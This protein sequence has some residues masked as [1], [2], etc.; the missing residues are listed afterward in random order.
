MRAQRDTLGCLEPWGGQALEALTAS[1]DL[2]A[3]RVLLVF[4]A[5][6]DTTDRLV[7][8]VRRALPALWE[9]REFRAI[10]VWLVCME[11][12][13]PLVQLQSMALLAYLALLALSGNAYIKIFRT[14]GCI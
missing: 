3:T 8:L 11:P 13:E 5:A 7:L 6:L 14:K 4:R 9:L 12:L 1:R 2:L 10:L